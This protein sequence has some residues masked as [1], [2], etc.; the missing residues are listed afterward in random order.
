[1]PQARE[2]PARQLGLGHRHH[3]SR[4][5]RPDREIAGVFAALDQDGA[6][7]LDQADGRRLRIDAGD[8]FL[9]ADS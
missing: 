5:H 8:V 1:V 4:Q 6:L 2:H 3:R 9:R 7:L